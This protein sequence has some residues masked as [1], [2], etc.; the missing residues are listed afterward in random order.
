MAIAGCDAG[1]GAIGGG[2]IIEQERKMM[3]LGVLKPDI[4]ASGLS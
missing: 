2:E 4:W 1:T 3:L